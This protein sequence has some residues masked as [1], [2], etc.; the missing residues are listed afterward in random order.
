MTRITF[1]KETVKEIQQKLGEA[2]RAG[3]LRLVRRISVLLGIARGEGIVTLLE[4]WKI[5]CADAAYNW[6]E[7]FVKGRWKVCHISNHPDARRG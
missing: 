6:L 3:D 5:T 1:H 2:Y 4:T 7:R